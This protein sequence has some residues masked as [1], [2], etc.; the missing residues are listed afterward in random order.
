MMYSFFFDKLGIKLRFSKTDQE[1]KGVSIE[2]NKI[3]GTLCPILNLS[4]YLKVRP[5]IK[6]PLLCHFSGAP[7][8]RYQFSVML[9]KTLKHSG[10]QDV[11]IF[12][13][14]SFRIRTAT[15]MA[16]SYFDCRIS[17]FHQYKNLIKKMEFSG[18]FAEQALGSRNLIFFFVNNILLLTFLVYMYKN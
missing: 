16:I 2:I 7:L 18:L 12:K 14:H 10:M 8:T 5:K 3:N 15:A 6:G 17:N 13:T 9:R 11:G 4:E 1:G